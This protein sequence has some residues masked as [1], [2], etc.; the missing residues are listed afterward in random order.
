LSS[1]LSG[2]LKSI[3]GG[4]AREKGGMGAE[5]KGPGPGRSVSQKR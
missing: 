3:G 5:R 4:G 2:R 1:G